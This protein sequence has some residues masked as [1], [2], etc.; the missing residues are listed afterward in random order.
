MANDPSASF[1]TRG[2]PIE[3][4]GADLDGR[5]FLEQ[6][7]TLT[8]TRDGATIPLANKLAPESELIVRNPVTNEEAD[9][10]VVDLI[11]DAASLHVYG[12]AFTNPSLNLWQVEFPEVQSQK[13]T[14]LKCSRCHAVEAILLGEIQMEIVESKQELRRHCECSNSWTIWKRTDQRVTERRAT[15]RGIKDRRRK[16]S[17]I[18][19]PTTPA[20]Q[21]RRREKRT[22]MKAAA[23]IRCCDGEVVVECEDVSRGGFRFKSLK[24]YPVG[25]RI[26]AAIPYA[27]SSVNIFVNTQIVYQQKLSGG[28]YRHGVAYVKSVKKPDSKS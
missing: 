20:L 23:C 19:E 16:I 8:I 11:Q 7:R 21:E 9:A 28:F 26:E 3:V 22:A 25:T 12:I 6:T 14:T 15:E 5:Q 2:L 27:K 17:P 24:A 4:F 13:T 1:F 10:R 18:E